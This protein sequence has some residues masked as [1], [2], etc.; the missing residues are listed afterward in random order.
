MIDLVSNIDKKTYPDYK[1]E[2]NIKNEIFANFDGLMDYDT[3]SI[4]YDDNIEQI[5]SKN[6][7]IK[8]SYKI[9]NFDVKMNNEQIKDQINYLKQVPQPEQRTEEWYK[10]RKNHITGSNAW[11]NIWNRKF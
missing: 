10:F 5:Y 6:G 8:R 2:L 11:K 4:I 9:M 3:F 1:F 7:L